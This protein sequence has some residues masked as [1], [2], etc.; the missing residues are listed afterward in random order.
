MNWRPVSVHPRVCGELASGRASTL[1]TSGS[2]PRVRGTR[3]NAGNATTRSPVHPRVCGELVHAHL[4]VVGVRRFIPACAGN[5]PHTRPSAARKPVHPR[6]CGELTALLRFGAGSYGSSPRVRGTRVYYGCEVATARFIPACAGNSAS[7]RA[8]TAT[9]PVHPRV[10]GELGS[11]RSDADVAAGS[12]PRVRGTP[13]RQRPDGQVRRFIPA[14]AGNSKPGRSSSIPVQRFIPACAGNSHRRRF[15]GSGQCGSS[16]RV[17]GTRP[18][19]SSA[20]SPVPVHPR[21]CGELLEALARIQRRDGSSPRV[22]GTHQRDDRA[23]NIRRFIPACA[24]NSAHGRSTARRAS[25]H[26][27][28]CGEL[29]PGRRTRPGAVRFIPACAGNSGV[30]PRKTRYRPVHPRVC[31]ELP[32]PSPLEEPPFR[33]IPRVRGTRELQTRGKGCSSVHP[34]VCGELTSHK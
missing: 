6:V 23:G 16:P 17:R 30:R 12:S 27:R 8:R 29:L 33:F 1:G 2:S 7:L 34:R 10:C 20:V 22:R 11:V 19:M 18:G 13:R 21:V 28:V 5:S 32:R 14:C 9:A 25:V 15:G 4:G 26:P 24:G 31:G 3:A